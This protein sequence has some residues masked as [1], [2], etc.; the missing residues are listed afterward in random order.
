MDRRV[1]GGG[2]E[3]RRD[4]GTEEGRSNE[5]D[6]KGVM[7][8]RYCSCVS[9]VGEVKAMGRGSGGQKH[10]HRHKQ[11]TSFTGDST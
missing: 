10:R 1:A 5:A 3:G 4:R 9:I 2:T 8:I 6:E 7:V 11:Q